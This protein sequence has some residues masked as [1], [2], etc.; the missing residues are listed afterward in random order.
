MAPDWKRGQPGGSWTDGFSSTA[1][2]L[3]WI[4]LKF[5]NDFLNRL[6]DLGSDSVSDGTLDLFTPLTGHSV[7]SLWNMYQN[8]LVNLLN[9]SLFEFPE[10]IKE[11]EYTETS[12]A[13]KLLEEKTVFEFQDTCPSHEGSKIFCKVFPSPEARTRDFS[14]I[15]ISLLYGS[16]PPQYFPSYIRNVKII[17]TDM[18]GVAHMIGTS[19]ERKEIHVS[20][21]HVQNV[22]SRCKDDLSLVVYYTL[23][24]LL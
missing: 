23:P 10:S 2:F 4:T 22:S 12:P 17:L 19:L 18:P 6:N 20:V 1:F 21:N 5:G 14:S 7:Q 15:V 8:T 11:V 16:S 9:I 24:Y 13:F 3:E